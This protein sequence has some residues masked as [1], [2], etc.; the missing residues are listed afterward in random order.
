VFE[1]CETEATRFNGYDCLA[2]IADPPSCN[3]S[4]REKNQPRI[5]AKED[6]PV[7]PINADNGR[8]SDYRME[9]HVGGSNNTGLR[10]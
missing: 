2:Q 5:G 9:Q 6:K 7:P 4:D 3:E 8:S 1:N 10:E